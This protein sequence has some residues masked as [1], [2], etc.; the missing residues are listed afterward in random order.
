[1]K[2]TEQYFPVVLFILWYNV[3]LTF[4][5]ADEILKARSHDKLS[6]A[7]LCIHTTNLQTPQSRSRDLSSQGRKSGYPVKRDCTYWRC[8]KRSHVQCEFANS[9]QKASE[10]NGKDRNKFHQSPTVCQH[11]SN[12]WYDDHT[13]ERV[14]HR[15][16]NTFKGFGYDETLFLVFDTSHTSLTNQVCQLCLVS[17]VKASNSSRFYTVLTSK[18]SQASLLLSS[19]SPD[20]RLVV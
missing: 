18:S 19:Y 3:V 8:S 9:K 15:Y 16:L 11:V 4:L 14:F 12:C 2:A 7:V 13:L 6:L 10:N 5:S 17:G 20:L 1:M